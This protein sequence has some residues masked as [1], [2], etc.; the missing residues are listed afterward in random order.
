MRVCE[1]VHVR[2]CMYEINLQ[3]VHVH[4]CKRV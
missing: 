2:A 3:C 4:A 1:F